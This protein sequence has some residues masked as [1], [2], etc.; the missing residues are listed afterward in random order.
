MPATATD[1]APVPLPLIS[2]VRETARIS[3]EVS[4]EGPVSMCVYDV[5]GRHIRTLVEANLPAGDHI[6]AWDGRDDRGF[7]SASGV[8]FLRLESLSDAVVRKVV[9]MK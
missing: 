6:A 8:Y 9:L 1:M 4:A 3:F 5:A 2:P 7:Q